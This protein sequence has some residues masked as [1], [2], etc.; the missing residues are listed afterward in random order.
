[1]PRCR[2]CSGQH[3]SRTCNAN[4]QEE[5]PRCSNCNKKHQASDKNCEFYQRA[6]NSIKKDD[7]KEENKP[8]KKKSFAEA[9][10]A[11]PKK[12]QRN[13][14]ATDIEKMVITVVQKTFA[15]LIKRQT[16]NI[17]HG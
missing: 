1:M 8:G 4:P 14:Q 15:D 10:G 3:E 6:M 2:T 5:D 12:G 17:Q 7:K 16:L 9:A 11:K 13:Q